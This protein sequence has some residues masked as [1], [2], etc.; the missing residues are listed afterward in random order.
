M[1]SAAQIKNHYPMHN[2]INRELCVVW[3]VLS[4][5]LY[6]WSR[7]KILADHTVKTKVA[8]LLLAYLNSPFYGMSRSPGLFYE[9]APKVTLRPFEASWIWSVRVYPLKI[10]GCSRI[11]SCSVRTKR[12]KFGHRNTSGVLENYFCLWNQR[13]ISSVLEIISAKSLK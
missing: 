7:S 1:S 10:E 8:R 5:I 13:N 11:R 4:H 2:T 6:S 12:W 9:W 3:C